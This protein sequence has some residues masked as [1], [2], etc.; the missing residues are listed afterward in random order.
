MKT[1]ADEIIN[2]QHNNT[3]NEFTNDNELKKKRSFMKNRSK[4]RA[5]GNKSFRNHN[6]LKFL[7]TKVRRRLGMENKL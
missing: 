6:N 1:L 4:P 7:N 2:G 5:A 3:V